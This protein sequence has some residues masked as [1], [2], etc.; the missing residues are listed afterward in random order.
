MRHFLL[1]ASLLVTTAAAVVRP[2][3]HTQI[4]GGPEV[5]WW[6]DGD[7]KPR[8]ATGLLYSPELLAALV[9]GNPEKS[10]PT[11]IADAVRDQTPIVVMWTFLD[12][13]LIKNITRPFHTMIADT[14]S[15]AV[16][17]PLWEKQDAADLRII[18][19]TRQFKNIGTMAAFP[20][21][22]FQ[23]GRV[24]VMY[25]DLPQDASSGGHRKVQV[26]GEFAG[27]RG[28]AK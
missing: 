5:L 14:T 8:T 22:A 23:P 27:S 4:A 11:S 19:P 7:G 6:R 21:T 20:Q 13:P 18:D 28:L 10:I 12:S 17:A 15:G 16:I 24:V 2:A 3:G 1:I 25:A 26:F 9:A